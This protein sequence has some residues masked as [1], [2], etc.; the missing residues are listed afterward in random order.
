LQPRHALLQRRRAVLQPHHALLLGLIHG[1][2]E[3]LPISSTAHIALLAALLRCPYE[4]LDPQLRKA[5]EVALHA[6]AGAA[7]AFDE[8]AVLVPAA[9]EFRADDAML[10]ACSLA[11]PALAGLLF[12]PLIAR[13]L[14]RP[15]AVAAGLCAGS[16]LMVL[17]D[18]RPEDR[19][20][21]DAHALDG[22]ALGLAQAAALAPGVSRTG[23]T[24]AAARARRFARADAWSLSRHAGLAVIAAAC[25]R[26]LPRLA[27]EHRAQALRRASSLGA[28][29][30][31]VSTLAA[32]RL[33]PRP[34]SPISDRSF[35]P[36]AP[37]A[38]Y[39]LLLAALIMRRRAK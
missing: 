27:G 3:L 36:L 4:D 28:A 5:F 34:R 11:P 12:E 2:A 39:R 21:A 8:R 38:F 24:V 1:P 25:A 30:A 18:R 19:T 14:S 17:A 29:G 7:L 6:G 37:L 9:A 20:R 31:F 16:F 32:L 10:I 26:G 22:L 33:Q 23:A 13:H 35:P 15:P